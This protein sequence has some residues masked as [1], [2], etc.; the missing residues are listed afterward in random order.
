MLITTDN[1]QMYAEKMLSSIL[2][3]GNQKHLLPSIIVIC[4]QN[5]MHTIDSSYWLPKE[6]AVIYIGYWYPKLKCLR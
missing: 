3:D 5:K 6:I 1:N 2:I 4:N